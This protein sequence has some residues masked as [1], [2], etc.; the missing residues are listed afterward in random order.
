MPFFSL[1]PLLLLLLPFY[2][3]CDSMMMMMTMMMIVR[4]MTVL[5]IM[6]TVGQRFQAEDYFFS[7][8]RG[9]LTETDPMNQSAI[10]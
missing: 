1:L 8:Y 9:L 6:L 2:S 10:S 5:M 3:A 7:S 4:M